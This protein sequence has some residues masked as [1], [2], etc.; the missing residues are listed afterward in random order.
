[1]QGR[2]LRLLTET[3]LDYPMER[4]YVDLGEYGTKLAET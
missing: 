1:M 2:D 4:E 3:A